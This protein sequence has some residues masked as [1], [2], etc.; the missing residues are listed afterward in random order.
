MGIITSKYRFACSVAISLRHIPDGKAYSR[1]WENH[2]SGQQIFAG[3]RSKPWFPFNFPL[4]QGSMS[5]VSSDFGIGFDWIGSKSLTVFHAVDGWWFSDSRELNKTNT[6]FKWCFKHLEL[7]SAWST[8]GVVWW[9]FILNL[10]AGFCPK[11]AMADTCPKK[12]KHPE[13]WKNTPSGKHLHNITMVY[14]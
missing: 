14:R 11:G 3:Q 4:N 12:T 9:P 7:A 13:M 8:S 1:W 5:I 6:M 2:R 10:L